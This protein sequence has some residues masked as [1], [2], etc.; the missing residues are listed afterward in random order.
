VSRLALD[1]PEIGELDLNPVLAFPGDAPA[2]VLDARL[3]LVT[4]A[5]APVPA[6]AGTP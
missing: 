6:A 4:P 3:K 1:H 5:G 2:V